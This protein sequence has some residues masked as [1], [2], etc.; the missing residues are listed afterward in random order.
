MKILNIV[1]QNKLICLVF[2]TAALLRFYSLSLTPPSLNWDE[3]SLG[4]NAYSI[5]K[6]GKD[7]WGFFLPNI[8]RA[9]GDY[10]LPGYIYTTSLSE[11]LLGITPFAV[12]FPSALGGILTVLFTYLLVQKLFNKNTATIAALLVA[13]EPWTIFL[14]RI[15]LEA[16]LGLTFFI[17]GLYFFFKSREKQPLFPLSIFFFG[18]SVWTYNSYRIFTPLMLLTLLVIYGKEIFAPLKK[19]STK[20]S[21]LAGIITAVVFFT[22]MFWQL[23]HPTGQARYEKVAILDSGAIGTIEHL[24]NNSNFPS[25][26][27]KLFYNRPAYFSFNFIKNWAT[28]F[29]PNFL[30][31]EGGSQYQFS[32]PK[33]GLVYVINSIFILIGLIYLVKQKSKNSLFLFSWLILGP[34]ASSITREAPHVLRAITLLPLPM[35]LAAVGLEAIK[36]TLKRKNKSLKSIAIISYLFLLSVLTG[37]YFYKY[38][39]EYKNDYSWSWQYGYK[40]T[41]DYIKQ[42]YNNYD[43]IIVTKKYGEPHEFLLFHWPW[44]PEKYRSDSNLVRFKQSDWYWVD[45]FDKFYFVND[46]DIPHE[47]NKIWKL[48]SGSEVPVNPKRTLLVTS[49]GNYPPDWSKLKTINFL[50]GSPAFEI[51]EKI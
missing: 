9:Y 37:V 4:F 28:H 32:M 8:F 13:V 36:S 31:I 27:T 17:S 51:L 42:N 21:L 39:T 24:R 22:P 16:N 14:S 11:I 2:L 50:D 45:R 35:I 40:E 34:I 26:V 19:Q 43:Q 49:P 3:V 20:L 29:S 6:T 12:R 18:L 10:K 46:W 41:V 38:F 44:D 47:T 15:A 23:L 30:F 48:E 25:Q 33:H 7:E 5:L 1:K